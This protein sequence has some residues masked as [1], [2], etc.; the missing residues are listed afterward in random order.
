MKENSNGYLQ[1]YFTLRKHNV[2]VG[3]KKMKASKNCYIFL[4]PYA[5]I[6]TMFYVFPVVA[7]IYFS[8]TYYN[9]LEPPRLIGLNNYISLL[10]EDDIFLIGIKNT[11]IIA[12]VTGP[13]GYIM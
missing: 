10:L 12:V 1:K 13:L 2:K 9:I 5:I 3:L 7:S 6:F 4:A 8:F 11:L